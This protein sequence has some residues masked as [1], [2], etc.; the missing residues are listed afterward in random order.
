MRGQLERGEGGLLHWQFVVY[1]TSRRR[2][3][4]VRQMFPGSHVE[5]TRSSAAREYV[6]KEDTRVDGTQLE[7]GRVAMQR[8]SVKDWEAI[9]DYSPSGQI[10]EIPADVRVRSYTTLRRIEKDFMVAPA[11]ER[12]VRVFYGRTGTGK[13]RRAWYEAGKTIRLTCRY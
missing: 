5:T 9:Y 6:W 2:A 10:Q 11:L 7:A 1:L 13:S 12:E 4:F 3:L 8:N